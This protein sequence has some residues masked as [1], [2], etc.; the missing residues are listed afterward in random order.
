M[1][2]HTTQ[3]ASSSADRVAAALRGFGPLGIVAILAILAGSAA[4]MILGAVLVLAWVWGS[5][6]PWRELGFVR[7]ASWIRTVAIGIVFGIAFKLLMKAMVMPLFGAPAI[8]PAYHYWV[9]NT[10]ALPRILFA[11]IIGAG[12]AE[13][14]V[15]RGYMFERL[16]KR[17]GSGTGAKEAMVLVTSALFAVDHFQGQGL[18]G[19]EQAAITGLTV[20]SIFAV[21]GQIWLPIVAHA[22]FDVTAVA[23]IY[24]DLESAVAHLVFR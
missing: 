14:T 16:G 13:E 20:G 9:G 18:A 6:T 2:Q 8:N 21:T 24:W 7:P 1:M 19:V 11:V 23:I 5:R 12:F 17:L 3:P 15:F 22:A 10:A 4:A